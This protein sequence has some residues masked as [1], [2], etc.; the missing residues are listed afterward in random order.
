VN[1]EYLCR[2]CSNICGERVKLHR[3]QTLSALLDDYKFFGGLSVHWLLVGSSGR[4]RRPESGGVLRYYN[5]CEAQGSPVT[6]IIANTFFVKNR[7]GHPHN[8][9]F[10]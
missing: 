5:R 9:F 10:R 3:N 6:K 4:E 2:P 1:D 7:A 8:M